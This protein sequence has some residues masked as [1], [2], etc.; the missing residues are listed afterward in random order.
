MT[1][2]EGKRFYQL[3]SDAWREAAIAWGTDPEQARAAAE[4][5]TAFYTGGP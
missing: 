4:R 5:T 3:S 1:S 2:D